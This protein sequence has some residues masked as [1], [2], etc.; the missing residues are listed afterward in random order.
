MTWCVFIATNHK[1]LFTRKQ[2]TGKIGSG[3][4]EQPS[5]TPHLGAAEKMAARGWLWSSLYDQW[6]MQPLPIF[7][8]PSVT[9]ELHITNLGHLLETGVATEHVHRYCSLESVL[10]GLLWWRQ[11]SMYGDFFF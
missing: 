3:L 11:Y 2:R 6:P 1:L 5:F 9:S 10:L 4:K 7:K 8:S